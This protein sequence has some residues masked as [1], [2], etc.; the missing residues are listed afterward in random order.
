MSK[1]VVSGLRIGPLI[2]FIAVGVGIGAHFLYG[3]IT[4]SGLRDTLWYHA[5]GYAIYPVFYGAL[6]VGLWKSARMLSKRED[7]LSVEGDQIAVGDQK[8]QFEEI[9][10]ISLR[11]NLVT[12]LVFERRNGRDVVL[13][14]WMLAR[15]AHEVIAHLNAL[16][17]RREAPA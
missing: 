7:Y 12:D 15:P 17:F 5:L 3:D 11:S 9:S 1:T 8:I 13:K 2:C 14:S 10:R 4:G 16:L 6:L